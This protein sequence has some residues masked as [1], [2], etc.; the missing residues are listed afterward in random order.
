MSEI[1]NLDSI[2]KRILGVIQADVS[3]TI[4]EV[5][6]RVGLSANP[7]WRRIKQMENAGVIKGR[8]AIIDGAR[9]GLGVACYV[10]VRTHRHD[11]AWLDT[12]AKAVKGISEIVECHRM[13]G[14]ID[15]LLKCV[16]SD[17]AH[18]DRVYKKLIAGVPELSD[19]S[20]C[21][22]MESLKAGTGIDVSST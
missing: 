10:F 2:D 8:V 16:V 1:Y 18:Y 7:C 5:A 15:Y 12:F 13:S 14:E 22:S 11:A 6:D 17:I 19:V 3:L 21:F 9:I 4:Q 20:S